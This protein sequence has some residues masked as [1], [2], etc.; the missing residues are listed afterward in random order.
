M[1]ALITRNLVM[2]LLFLFHHQQLGRQIDKHNPI[3]FRKTY[4]IQSDQ[5]YCKT[6]E[7]PDIEMSFKSTRT[8]NI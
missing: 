4:W 1:W 5:K 6:D 2:K 8:I 7:K 3:K